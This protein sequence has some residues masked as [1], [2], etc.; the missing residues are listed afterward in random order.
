[1]TRSRGDEVVTVPE[2]L[3]FAAVGALALI[4]GAH[5]YLDPGNVERAIPF[6]VPP[7]HARFLGSLY[8]SGF[9]MM[10]ASM[11]ARRWG[12]IRTIPV[13]TAVWTGGLGLISLADLSVFPF[14][15]VQTIVWFA[16]YT[17]YPIVGICLAW[18]HRGEPRQDWT[19][20]AWASPALL[21]L[22]GVLIASSVALLLIPG[23]MARV[24]PWA[25]TPLLARI[26]A[27]PMAAY[28]TLSVL[29]ARRRASDDP[30]IA[31]AGIGMFTALVLLAS[32]IH[33]SLFS[34]GQASDAA[35]FAGLAV[36]TLGV[37]VLFVRSRS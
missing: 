19:R 29:V 1:M 16:A 18:I 8:L 27:A 36:V 3:Y 28:G 5:G 15:R 34:L 4:V 2:R 31:L 12:Q 37:A 32:I 7:L 30:R 11:A 13:G 33:R 10:V 17:V 21:G 26:Y 35:W 24:W 23:T 14:E 6:T 9:V 22:G 20:P 25:I